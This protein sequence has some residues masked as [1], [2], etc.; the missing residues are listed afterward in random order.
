MILLK[1][2]MV[3]PGTHLVKNYESRSRT[4]ELKK[5]PEIK[6]AWAFM[7][8]DNYNLKTEIKTLHYKVH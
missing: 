1:I 5:E 8:P 2:D 7:Q 6:N 3:R 4:N